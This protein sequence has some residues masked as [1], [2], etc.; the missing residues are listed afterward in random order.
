MDG[1]PGLGR[2]AF[3]VRKPNIDQGVGLLY[4]KAYAYAFASTQPTPNPSF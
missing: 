3:D 4:E 2:V 1:S